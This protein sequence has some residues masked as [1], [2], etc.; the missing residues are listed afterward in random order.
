VS[1]DGELRFQVVVELLQQQR[2][3]LQRGGPRLTYRGGTTLILDART[4]EILYGVHKRLNEPLRK[5]RQLEFWSE[6]EEGHS[7]AFR[8]TDGAAPEADFSR[9]HRGV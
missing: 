6:W 9:L 7:G 2:L 3:Q 8:A 1:P 4:G 5:R